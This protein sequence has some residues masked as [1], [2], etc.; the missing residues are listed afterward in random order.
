[1]LRRSGARGSGDRRI[2][3]NPESSIKDGSVHI[4][5]AV[6][7]KN[8]DMEDVL[9]ITSTLIINELREKASLVEK[10]GDSYF[11]YATHDTGEKFRPGD[12]GTPFFG[13]GDNKKKIAVHSG[14][15]AAA[16]PSGC[17][18]EH[19]RILFDI[20][21]DTRL[22]RRLSRLVAL[23]KP[24]GRVRGLVLG[25]VFRRLVA[26]TLAQ[27]LAARFQAACMPFQY[28]LSTRA[29]A[30]SLARALRVGTEL[31]PRATVL[32]VDGVGAYDHA[33]LAGL[34]Q[35][36]SLHGLLPY[37]RQ[38]YG[39]QS[40]SFSF[41]S[42]QRLWGAPKLPDRLPRTYAARVDAARVRGPGLEAF[43]ELIEDEDHEGHRLP[44]DPKSLVL[45]ETY[46]S[47]VR[48]RPKD[49]SSTTATASVALRDTGIL[50][51]STLKLQ[52]CFGTPDP[53]TYSITPTGETLIAT[54]PVI[55]L[56]QVHF[57]TDDGRFVALHQQNGTEQWIHK[58]GGRIR[59]SPTVFE[60]ILYF[61]SDDGYLYAL[62]ARGG[63]EMWRFQA[64][65]SVS[66]TPTVN[67]RLNRLFFGADNGVM[68]GLHIQAGQLEWSYQTGGPI[69][70]SV[71][72]SQNIRQ[73]QI[74]F[75]SDDG[76][77][78]ALRESDGLLMWRFDTSG[79]VRTTAAV[80]HDLVL[81]GS[82]SGKFYGIQERGGVEV[83]HF[84]AKAAIYT[85]AA[86]H[87][88]FVFFGCDNGMMYA[89][90]ETTGEKVWEYNSFSQIR[91]SIAP[92]I[93][94]G[95]IYFGTETR[96]P[97]AERAEFGGVRRQRVNDTVHGEVSLCSRANQR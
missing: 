56:Q 52:G 18:N 47:G 73:D 97:S 67:D 44:P 57:G 71:A 91:S 76:F 72:M 90:Q 94:A 77:V 89:L 34:L 23:Q 14:I 31:A 63:K 12:S 24:N 54:T 1:M 74:Y 65:G 45:H 82:G 5:S 15:R 38:F 64:N 30:E 80:D 33:M 60:N 6:R 51:L 39:R 20:E 53:W 10:A 43:T 11:A 37:A 86:V 87:R 29:G 85:S 46:S 95:L 28:A 55:Y 42:L 59:S 19:L 88:G 96:R 27:Q 32:S 61:G 75:G 84:D 83:W 49:A 58:T 79:P 13:T 35:H 22:L 8:G 16:G 7:S 48:W 26:R 66:S 69:S 62:N 40:E 9:M 41:A 4:S 92:A 2:H 36:D 93:D 17:T 78:Y 81:V 21:E 68:Y 70:S 3:M 50:L 25:D